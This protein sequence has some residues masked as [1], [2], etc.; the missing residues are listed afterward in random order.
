[1]SMPVWQKPKTSKEGDVVRNTWEA[2][3]LE[4]NIIEDVVLSLTQLISWAAYSGKVI[5]QCFSER[6]KF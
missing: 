2:L 4:L 1:M 5:I 3:A 6:M